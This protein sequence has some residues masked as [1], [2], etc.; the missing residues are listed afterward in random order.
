MPSDL[1]GDRWDKV[2]LLGWRQIVNRRPPARMHAMDEN[3]YQ[4]SESEEPTKQPP[5]PQRTTIWKAAL[6]A[7]VVVL[8]LLF[9]ISLLLPPI[10]AR[11]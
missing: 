2:S 7:I 6:I 3:P 10:N 11:R 8:A 1:G 4:T 5:R 9:I